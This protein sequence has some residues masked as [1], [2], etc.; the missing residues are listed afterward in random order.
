MCSIRLLGLSICSCGNPVFKGQG[1]E[2]HSHPPW[3]HATK[4]R[5][6]ETTADRAEL[7]TAAAT[8]AAEAA[9]QC[10]ATGAAPVDLTAPQLHGDDTVLPCSREE[11]PEGIAQ[12]VQ[13]DQDGNE[14]VDEDEDGEITEPARDLRKLDQ[15]Q[16]E[17]V[18]LQQ[19]KE[20]L[21]QQAAVRN[22]I[23]QTQQAI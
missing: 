4:G 5:W 7:S 15:Y 21:L 11:T 9:P 3:Y 6:S 19:E 20:Q 16:Q 12:D 14:T 17:I 13:L 10:G 23:E 18:R 2:Q 8:A 22:R 1:L